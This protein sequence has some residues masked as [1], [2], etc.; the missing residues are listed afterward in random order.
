MIWALVITLI[1]AT[2]GGQQAK[3]AI[4]PFTTQAACERARADH[5]GKL[6][7]AQAAKQQQ[8]AAVVGCVPVQIPANS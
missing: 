8:F 5:E 3:S 4:V 2:P 1:I 6:A 7:A